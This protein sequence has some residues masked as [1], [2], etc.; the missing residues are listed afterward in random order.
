MP[1]QR[2][3]L[4]GLPV[5]GCVLGCVLGLGG[6]RPPCA[7]K[8][9]RA[10]PHRLAL[11]TEH[12]APTSTW[13]PARSPAP[14]PTHPL[15]PPS[16]PPALAANEYFD[17][18]GECFRKAVDLEPGNDSYRRA[19]EM[20][21][22]APQLYQ[23]LQRQLQVRALLHGK[24]CMCRCGSVALKNRLQGACTVCP[25]PAPLIGAA[26]LPQLSC[27]SPLALVGCCIRL[28]P[29]C[30]CPPTCRRRA[31]AA[32]LVPPRAVPRRPASRCD[33]CL[34]TRLRAA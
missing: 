20:S 16:L 17:K 30:T 27:G 21:G 12:G 2:L 5:C 11:V 29:C 6:G 24:G 28:P 32:P 18:A 19:L 4:P 10:S 34:P 3:H 22:K 13:P 7:V 15:L 25:A 31:R 26:R 9:G 33:A 8:T 14:H 23:E 1:G